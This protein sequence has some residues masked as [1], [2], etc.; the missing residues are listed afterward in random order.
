[1]SSLFCHRSRIL[2]CSLFR[3]G[4]ASWHSAAQTLRLCWLLSLTL[5]LPLSLGG[6]E[7]SKEEAKPAP[8]VSRPAG[9]SGTASL[10]EAGKVSRVYPLSQPGPA[11][12]IE[13]REQAEAVVEFA[14]EAGAVVINGLCGRYPLLV[15]REVQAYRRD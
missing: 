13:E 5:C 8:S 3:G 14:N 15:M 1:M 10:P 12:T 7:E 4:M 2:L 9:A 11:P 6:C